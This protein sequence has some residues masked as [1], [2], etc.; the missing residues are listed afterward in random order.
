VLLPSFIAGFSAFTTAQYL[1]IEYTYYNINFT[2]PTSLDISLI[3]TVVVAGVFFGLVS[4]MTITILKKVTEI[5]KKIKLNVYIK[6]FG[7]GVLLIILSYFVGDRYFGLGLGTIESVLQNDIS[8]TND[9]P[10]YAF[11]L[12]TIF[13]A[14]TL[15]GG[16]S[17]GI[18]TPIFYIGSTSGQLF[19][20]LMGDNV[21]FYAALG[22]VSVLAGTTNAPIAATIISMELFGLE[23]AHYAAI[24]IVISFLITG[25]R[26]VF[27]SQ[28]LAMKKSDLL[29]IDMG[30]DIAQTRVNMGHSQLDKINSI[31]NKI[32]N[33]TKV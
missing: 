17:G 9:L 21:V 14:I 31:K 26:S 24:S 30:E 13:T 7:A 5:L 25:H 1:G 12:K 15:A 18:V 20:T 6:A 27:S 23:V 22:F 32:R 16:G 29:R 3:L 2:E 4:D 8:A 33:K 19:G 11:I 28:I 10:W